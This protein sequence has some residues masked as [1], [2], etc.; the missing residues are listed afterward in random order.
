M[1]AYVVIC[2]Y[3][4]SLSLV[5]CVFQK[6]A[7]ANAYAAGLNGDREKAVARCKVLIA[8]RDSDGMANFL[9]GDTVIFEVVSA[10]LR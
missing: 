8:L 10:E 9:D 1:Q 5:D 3:N 4:V 2:N 7:D 6:K